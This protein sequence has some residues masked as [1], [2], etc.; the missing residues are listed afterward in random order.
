M[1]DAEIAA[2][3]ARLADIKTNLDALDAE[4][5][6][7]TGFKQPDEVVFGTLNGVVG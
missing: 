3:R 2:A 4:L 6:D 1:T 7:G 5:A